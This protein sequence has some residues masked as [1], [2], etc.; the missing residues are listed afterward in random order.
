MF[1]S[2]CEMVG[3]SLC[4]FTECLCS[5]RPCGAGVGDTEMKDTVPSQEVL[6]MRWGEE[7]SVPHGSTWG[8]GVVVV[9][10]HQGC[11][12]VGDGI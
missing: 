3:F 10:A 8:E 1:A 7:E 2:P 5:A 9:R 11:L 4:M 6:L 12:L